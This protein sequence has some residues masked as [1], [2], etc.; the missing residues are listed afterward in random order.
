MEVFWSSAI[1]QL[2]LI[3]K[4]LNQIAM[5]NTEMQILQIGIGAESMTS[6]VTL[7]KTQSIATMDCTISAFP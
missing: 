6:T 3:R 2:S 4:N 5:W 7:K 1:I